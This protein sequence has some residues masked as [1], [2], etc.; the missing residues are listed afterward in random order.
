[1]TYSWQIF[2]RFDFIRNLFENSD[3]ISDR[4]TDKESIIRAELGYEIIC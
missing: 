4:E 1:M 3:E 2:Y